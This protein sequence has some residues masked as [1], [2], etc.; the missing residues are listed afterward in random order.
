MLPTCRR[1]RY[2]LDVKRDPL[3]DHVDEVRAQWARELPDLDT[4][5]VAVVLR[6]ARTARSLDRRLHPLLAEHGV[7]PEGFDTLTALRRVGPPYRLTPTDL[8]RSL[9][10]TSGTMTNRLRKLEAA[11]LIRRVADPEDGRG[12]LVELTRE[13]RE[14]SGHLIRVHL[15]SERAAL[16]AL[17]ARELDALSGLLRKLLLAFEAE[18]PSLDDRRRGR[19]RRDATSA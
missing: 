8:Y 16:A 12:M 15:D 7:T 6:L 3:Q 10:R 11:G 4:T 17:S 2:Y 9:M 13:G 14:L 18:E 19:K 5:P 1:R